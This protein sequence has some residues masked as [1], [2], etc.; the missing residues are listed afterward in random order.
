MLANFWNCTEASRLAYSLCSGG[1]HFNQSILA[2]NGYSLGL[3]VRDQ[4]GDFRQATVGRVLSTRSTA[5]LFC[6]LSVI[7][8]D[9]VFRFRKKDPAFQYGCQ[10]DQDQSDQRK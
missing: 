5:L 9:D 8:R 6:L 3:R 10:C 1:Q 2:L 4:I 7:E